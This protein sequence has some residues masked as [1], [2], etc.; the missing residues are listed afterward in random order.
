MNSDT[1]FECSEALVGVN[2]G[3]TGRTLPVG[4]VISRSASG[5]EGSRR[6]PDVVLGFLEGSSSKELL[7]DVPEIKSVSPDALEEKS[8]GTDEHLDD[9]DVHAVVCGIVRN[10]TSPLVSQRDSD[11]PPDLYDPEEGG[12]V[13]AVNVAPDVESVNNFNRS[14][15]RQKPHNQEGEG[16]DSCHEEVN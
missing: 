11:P 6:I 10:E 12:V 4:V 9:G 5:S 1:P 16:E 13:P 8:H 2:A 3:D 15:V 7:L 14:T